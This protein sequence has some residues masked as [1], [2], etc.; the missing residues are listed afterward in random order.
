MLRLPNPGCTPPTD[1][2]KF[3]DHSP[4]GSLRCRSDQTPIDAP[5]GRIKN[6][7]KEVSVTRPTLRRT[8]MLERL[9]TRQVLSGVAGLAADKQYVVE[10]INLVRTDP[11]AA[12]EKLTANLGPDVQ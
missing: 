10:L 3:I 5:Q 9:E 6:M 8:P 11:K 4:P 12:G 1:F 7:A 2:L